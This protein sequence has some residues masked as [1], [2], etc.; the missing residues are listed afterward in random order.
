MEVRHVC[1]S[2]GELLAVHHH[3]NFQQVKDCRATMRPL[4]EACASWPG[5]PFRWS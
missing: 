5:C 3:A 1:E 2:C 4:C